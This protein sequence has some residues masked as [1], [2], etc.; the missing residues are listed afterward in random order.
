MA[1][2]TNHYTD[3]TNEYTKRERSTQ[4]AKGNPNKN[5]H[6]K[7][8]GSN[9]HRMSQAVLDKASK[10]E[11]VKLPTWLYIV[12]G[13]LFVAV[14]VTLILRLTVLK[15]NLTAGYLSSLLLGVTCGMLFYVRKAY[16]KKK[17]GALYS[18][19]GLVLVVMCLFYTVGG[20]AGLLGF[21]A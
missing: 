11:R 20:V 4:K 17:Q 6:A 18:I 21:L 9:Y 16:R 1:R 5:V 13:A 15:E 7:K 12:M 10:Q 14:I 8:N 19:I 3:L 2:H